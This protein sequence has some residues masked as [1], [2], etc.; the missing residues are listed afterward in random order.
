MCTRRNKYKSLAARYELCAK[1]PYYERVCVC[2]CMCAR[3][4]VPRYRRR[5]SEKK[6]VK[7]RKGGEGE[8]VW[9]YAS[10]VYYFGALPAGPRGSLR[11]FFILAL[12]FFFLFG[13]ERTKGRQRHPSRDEARARASAFFPP[14]PPPLPLCM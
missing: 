12:I 5:S 10:L 14:P 4:H 6:S 11:V 7:E 8:T 1:N 9:K 2:V 13:Q 3:A